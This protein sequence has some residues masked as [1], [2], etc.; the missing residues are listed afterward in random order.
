MHKERYTNVTFQIDSYSRA[1]RG[2]LKFSGLIHG[3]RFSARAEDINYTQSDF[4]RIEKGNAVFTT[5]VLF[6]EQ[7]LFSSRPLSS[8][9]LRILNVRYAKTTLA[10]AF[11]YSFFSCF[12]VLSMTCYGLYRRIRDYI[13]KRASIDRGDLDHPVAGRKHRVDERREKAIRK[14]LD[15]ARRRLARKK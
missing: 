10:S 3:E 4:H 6:A 1:R 12:L 13:D 8:F 15:A 7:P 11:A 9:D 2:S 14:Q 5:E